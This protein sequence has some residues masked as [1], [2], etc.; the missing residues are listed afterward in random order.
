MITKS[1][2]LLVGVSQVPIGSAAQLTNRYLPGA[3]YDV[4]RL[5]TLLTKTAYPNYPDIEKLIYANASWRNFRDS[6]AYKINNSNGQDSFLFIHYTGHSFKNSLNENILCFSDRDV[7][8]DEFINALATIPEKFT[9]FV[10]LNACFSEGIF[11]STNALSNGPIGFLSSSSKDGYAIASPKTD[12]L[13]YFMRYFID[14]WKNFNELNFNYT[15]F[16]NLLEKKTNPRVIPKFATFNDTNHFFET[17]VPL[18]FNRQSSSSALNTD[19]TLTL[20]TN[21]NNYIQLDISEPRN[22]YFVLDSFTVNVEDKTKSAYVDALVKDLGS[23]MVRDPLQN[24]DDVKYIG[25]VLIKT[26]EGSTEL[27][28][29]VNYLY[30]DDEHQASNGVVVIINTENNF[31]I[32]AKGRTKGKVSNVIGGKSN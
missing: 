23:I 18:F 16:T 11:E 30:S 10:C 4:D 1:Y 24:W 25:V 29:P 14:T 12:S 3:K 22:N 26:G 28:Y 31:Q 7:H 2:A 32:I 17:T 20:T 21:S 15:S 5:E 13:T 27:P 9:T 8:E 6:L 19:P